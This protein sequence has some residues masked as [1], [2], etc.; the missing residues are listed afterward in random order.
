MATGNELHVMKHEAES[1]QAEASNRWT[2]HGGLFLLSWFAGLLLITAAMILIMGGLTEKPL[3]FAQ[4]IVGVVLVPVSIEMFLLPSQLEK[5]DK[6]LKRLRE[7]ASAS[8]DAYFAAL[9]VEAASYGIDTETRSERTEYMDNNFEFTALR[10]GE[11]IDV[12]VRDFNTEI[13]FMLN[14]ERMSKLVTV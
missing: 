7:V 5:M 6:E 11:P 2:R 8:C 14:G 3:G 12:T 13:V 9:M 4:V 10:N 1:A